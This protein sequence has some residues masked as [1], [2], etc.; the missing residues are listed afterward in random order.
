MAYLAASARAF[1]SSDRAVSSS[2]P[3]ISGKV[4]DTHGKPLAGICVDANLAGHSGAAPGPA[5]PGVKTG[6]N[7]KY[8]IGNGR[9]SPGRWKVFFSVG[10]GN[11]G[12]FAPQWWKFASTQKLVTGLGTG[13]YSVSFGPGCG[14]KG[15]FAPQFY[16][17][18]VSEAA[19]SL[20]PVKAGANVHGRD[21]DM[22]PGG[23]V[24]G[25][26]TNAAGK[27][28]TG[29]CVLLQQQFENTGGGIDIAVAD[30]TGPLPF[31]AITRTAGVTSQG[32][33]V[34]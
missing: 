19:T 17:N 32:S 10:C 8:Q 33:L 1:R 29:V 6:R 20:V 25:T 31:G 23:T 26:V 34:S 4:T 28:L 22:R 5:G 16:K 2:G 12:N 30:G 21:A 11:K 27:K 15:S 13:R 3:Q 24:T 7:G 14:N 18:Q 9:L